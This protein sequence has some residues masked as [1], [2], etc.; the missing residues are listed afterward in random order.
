LKRILNYLKSSVVPF[1]AAYAIML[2][3]SFAFQILYQL[4]IS[5]YI[6]R[7]QGV[8]VLL[9]GEKLAGQINEMMSP[10]VL[11][12]ISVAAAVICGVIFYFWYRHETRGLQKGA[13]SSV[14]HSKT[15]LQFLLL[16]ISCQLFFSGIM[17][18]LQPLL[19][20][21]F[22]SYGDM[23]EGLL[24]SNLLLVLLY[25]IL[26]APVSEELIFRGVILHRAGKVL[27]FIGANLLQALFFGIY[28]GNIIQGIYA[29]AMGFLLGLIYRKYNTIIASIFL[30]MIINASIFV[31]MLF[32]LNT[33]SYVAMFALGVVG[34]AIALLLLKLWGDRRN[35]DIE[36][37]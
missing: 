26:I 12:L 36:V 31:V 10:N 23:M 21:L 8:K 20:K 16:G 32:P 9:D 37:I 24:G 4:I 19:P 28:H 29:T 7:S 14:F 3:V 6:G 22:D 17:N 5:V 27:P 1:L 15:I 18:L 30:H 33:I 2:A 35:T 25:T 13:L 11:Y 34:S